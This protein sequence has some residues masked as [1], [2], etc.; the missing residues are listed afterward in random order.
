VD[1][2]VLPGEPVEPDAGAPGSEEAGTGA[3][4]PGTGT[5]PLL[6]H[7]LDPEPAQPLTPVPVVPLSLL[8]SVILLLAGGYLWYTARLAASDSNSV[9]G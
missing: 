3:F 6:V 2:S 5:T 4:E 7:T 8:Y 9:R 1:G